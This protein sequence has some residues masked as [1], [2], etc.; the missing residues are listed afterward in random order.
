M[1]KLITTF[2][3]FFILL[4]SCHVMAAGP[5]AKKQKGIGALYPQ[6]A[7][8]YMKK[9]KDLVI[10]DVS[11]RRRYEA[12]HFTHSINIPIEDYSDEELK[13]IFI[14]EIPKGRPVLLHCRHGIIVPAAYESLK[15]VRPDIPEVSYIAGKPPFDEFNTWCEANEKNQTLSNE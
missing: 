7:I 14:K 15:I 10:I 3:A 5:S 6:Q 1:K 12:K 2:L 13:S 4:S 8:E 11:S 9:T